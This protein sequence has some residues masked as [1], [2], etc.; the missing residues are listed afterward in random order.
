VPFQLEAILEHAAHHRGRLLPRAA[1]R[2]FGG[3][4]VGVAGN[5]VG[6]ALDLAHRHW[7]SEEQ[8]RADRLIAHRQR[9]VGRLSQSAAARITRTALDGDDFEFSGR[10]LRGEQRTGQQHRAEREWRAPHARIMR[11]EVEAR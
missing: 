5:P 2:R 9:A 3:D 1:G 8:N 10:S 11:R 6:E 4:V 7:R